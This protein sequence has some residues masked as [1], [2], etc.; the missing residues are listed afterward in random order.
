MLIFLFSVWETEKSTLIPYAAFRITSAF[1]VA[2][3]FSYKGPQA[4][5]TLV[6]YFYLCGGPL[7]LL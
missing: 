6:K 3:A 4:L 1:A 7:A 2:N 5:I